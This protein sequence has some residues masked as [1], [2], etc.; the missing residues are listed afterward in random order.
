[1]YI[2]VSGNKKEV[3]NGLTLPELIELENVEMP[4]YVTVSVNDEFLDAD[5][6]AGTVLKDGDNVEFLYFMGGGC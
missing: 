2:T 3:K 6:K 1:M 5:K 4:D